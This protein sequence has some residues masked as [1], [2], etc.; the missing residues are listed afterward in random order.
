MPKLKSP[1]V[2]TQA[3]PPNAAPASP[4][5][6]QALLSEKT[7]ASIVEAAE[8]PMVKLTGRMALWTSV[9]GVTAVLALGS[10][11]LQWSTMNAQLREMQ[12]SSKDAQR[13]VEA[14]TKQAIAAEHLKDAGLAQADAAASQAKAMERLKIA[15]EAQAN[16]SQNL[17]DAG[18]TQAASTKDL[19]R[20]TSNQLSALQESARASREQAQAAVV[21]SRA[22]DRLAQSGQS[23]A[24]AVLKSLDVARDAN[25][26][27]ARASEA[28]ER[29]WV[30]LLVADEAPPASLKEWPVWVTMTNT[31]KSPAL[32]VTMTTTVDIIKVPGNLGDLPACGPKCQAQTL[33]IGQ[34]FG[35]HPNISADKLTAEEF[36]RIS[37]FEDAIVTRGRVDYVD[38][39]GKSHTT[40]VCAYYMPKLSSM[41][42]CISGNSAN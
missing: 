2:P 26:I 20:A 39:N 19:V 21:A 7:A 24:A 9:M 17:A 1:E 22:T 38:T 3:P 18:D 33:F 5:S 10:S 15:G 14:A 6:D 35:Q 30:S 41:T 13:L 31:G 37:A 4:V 12:S 29:P 32:H 40:F 16:A 23:Q 34:A 36:K 25:I 42:S 8:E 27:A 28:A 11:L